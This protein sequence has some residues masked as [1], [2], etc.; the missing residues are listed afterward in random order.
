MESWLMSIPK[1]VSLPLGGKIVPMSLLMVQSDRYKQIECWL[2]P[3]G[4]V[5]L[6]GGRGRNSI[7]VMAR[8]WDWRVVS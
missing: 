4:G 7:R 3:L 1:P 5:V 6:D 8:T 2:V